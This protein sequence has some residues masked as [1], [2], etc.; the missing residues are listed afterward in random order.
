[1]KKEF[2]RR[3]MSYGL[4]TSYRGRT[5]T[6]FVRPLTELGRKNLKL[7]KQMQWVTPF[8]VQF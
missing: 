1:M 5:R 3:M 2:A 7:V 8:E 4:S 6:M